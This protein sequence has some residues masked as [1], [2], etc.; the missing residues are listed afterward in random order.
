VTGRLKDMVIRGG[1]NMFPAEIESALIEHPSV[2][3]VAVIGVP[4]PRMGEE[5]VAFIRVSGDVK[6]DIDVLR[7]HLRQRLAAPKTPRYWVFLP[8]FPLT[9]S[10][11]IQK[12]LL[13]ERW[14][15]GE[16]DPVDS[17]RRV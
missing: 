17:A 9:G 5:L 14:G 1:E 10:G 11:K 16:Y 7:Q 6:P 3:E 2:T 12:F 4:D 8:E 13:R 15:Q